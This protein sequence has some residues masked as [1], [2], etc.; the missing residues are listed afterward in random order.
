MRVLQID[1]V[2]LAMPPGG[3]AEAIAFYSGVLGIPHV[4][5]PPDLAVNG[6]CWFEAGS[7]KVHL[8]AQ[9]DFTPAKKAHP[10]LLVDDLAAL[11]S[12]VSNAGHEVF[13]DVPVEG[14]DRVF[15][16]D[17]F[18][19]RVEFMQVLQDSE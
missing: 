11:K 10:A 16:H 17:P 12:A 5:K 8:G 4:A 18:G 1:H 14:Y 7:L 6:G 19:N 3:E 13:D 15:S 2:Q 9:A